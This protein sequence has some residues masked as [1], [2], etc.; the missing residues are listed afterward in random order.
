MQLVI[1][2]EGSRHK[3]TS[4]ANRRCSSSNLEVEVQFVEDGARSR[5]GPEPMT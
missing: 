5:N 4:G 3:R 2:Y 1:L